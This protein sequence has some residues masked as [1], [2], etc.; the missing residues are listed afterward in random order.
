MTAKKPA[1]IG[2]ENADELREAIGFTLSSSV[3][4]LPPA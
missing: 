2:H 3:E 4:S 1:E